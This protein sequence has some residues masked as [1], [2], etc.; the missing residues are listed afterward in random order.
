MEQV[1][2]PEG[3]AS[4]QVYVIGSPGSHIVKIGH[5]NA[6]KKRLWLLQVGSPVELRLLAVF[7]GGQALEAALHRY[8]GAFHVR[9]EW[10]ALGDDPVKAVREAVALGVAG[11]RSEAGPPTLPGTTRSNGFSTGLDMPSLHAM[12]GID[13]DIRFPRL[14]EWRVKA[15]LAAHGI[16]GT[17]TDWVH[18][19]CEGCPDCLAHFPPRLTLRPHPV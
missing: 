5:S 10:F 8:F 19:A 14:P 17:G 13:W 6:P 3:D 16:S 15:V 4:G 2:T 1:M 11:L 9:G 18:H 12:E 7:V